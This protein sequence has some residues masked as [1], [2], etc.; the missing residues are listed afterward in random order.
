MIR[1]SKDTYPEGW[2]GGCVLTIMM[3]VWDAGYY[4]IL[5]KSHISDQ[6]VHNNSQVDDVVNFGV[7]QCYRYFVKGSDTN[8]Q[9]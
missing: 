7:R 3:D 2:C 9:A 6:I 5:V 4:N 1:L 8:V